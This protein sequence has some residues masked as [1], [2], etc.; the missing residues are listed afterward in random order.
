MITKTDNDVVGQL[1]GRG[2]ETVVCV[3]RAPLNGLA[4][5]DGRGAGRDFVGSSGRRSDVLRGR[6]G[7]PMK[8]GPPSA[9]WSTRR[10]GTRAW[11]LTL[12]L[13][14]HVTVRH[15]HEAV[16]ATRNAEAARVQLELLHPEH[17]RLG[18]GGA[19]R[20]GT[21]YDPDRRPRSRGHGAF[22]GEPA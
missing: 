20:R 4:L 21:A 17:A 10:N 19:G 6:A 16:E 9:I 3:M 11:Q 12:P 13:P 18:A 7:H 14:A 2:G 22:P 8:L 1:G 5:D 15:V